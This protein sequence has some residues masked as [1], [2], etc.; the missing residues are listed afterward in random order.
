MNVASKGTILRI[1]INDCGAIPF[2]SG[3]SIIDLAGLNN[4][5]IALAGTTEA[6]RNEIRE[7]KPQLVVLVS[8]KKH[9]SGKDG[10][11]GW[12]RLSNDDVIKLGYNYAGT[13][14][15]GTMPNGD[16]YHLLVYANGDPLVLAFLDRL[17]LTGV[18]DLPS[19]KSH[20]ENDGNGM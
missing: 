11:Y 7:K 17:A 16:G 1:A 8:K 15:V 5:A 13:M 20:S 10:I 4:R 12:E 19:V 6:T 2:Y 9:P 18:L 3:F 14:T